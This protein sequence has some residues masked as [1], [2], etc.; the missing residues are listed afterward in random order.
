MTILRNLPKDCI[1]PSGQ[2]PSGSSS[3]E[4]PRG[5]QVG[6]E[7]VVLKLIGGLS[8]LLLLC[9]QGVEHEQRC[10]SYDGLTSAYWIFIFLLIISIALVL[11]QDMSVLPEV[12]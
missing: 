4:C 9:C 12:G 11:F 8:N 7:H 10:G 1:A 6:T 5:K 2:L 3:T